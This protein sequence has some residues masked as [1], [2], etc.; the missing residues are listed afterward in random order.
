MDLR[1]SLPAWV[2]EPVFGRL[3]KPGTK[4]VYI[5]TTENKLGGW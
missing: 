2:V 3:A 5:P 1:S 4:P